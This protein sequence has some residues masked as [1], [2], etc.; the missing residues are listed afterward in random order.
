MTLYKEPYIPINCEFHDYLEHFATLKQAITIVYKDEITS[1]KE[2]IENAFI[3]DL[4]GGRNGEFSH[5]RY[6]AGE[7]IIRNDY[8]I[9]VGDVKMSDFNGN[10]CEL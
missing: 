3:V 1:K 8:L 6:Q 2:I 7:K 5:I 10:S 4:T 9:S